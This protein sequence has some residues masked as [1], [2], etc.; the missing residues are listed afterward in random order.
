MAVVTSILA[1]SLAWQNFFNEHL[2]DIFMPAYYRWIN[3]YCNLYVINREFFSWLGKTQ[4]AIARI[5][6]KPCI[7]LSF[8]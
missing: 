7:V 3:L 8:C 5:M 6:V 4:D 1:A 2:K